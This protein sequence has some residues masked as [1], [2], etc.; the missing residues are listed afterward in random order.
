MV[1]SK[2]DESTLT[3]KEL[4]RRKDTLEAAKLR[5]E[6]WRQRQK[7]A[8]AQLRYKGQPTPYST[9]DPITL[10]DEEN[11]VAQEIINAALAQVARISCEDSLA[12]LIASQKEAIAQAQAKWVMPNWYGSTPVTLFTTPEY[13]RTRITDNDPMRPRIKFLI[14]HQLPAIQNL[15]ANQIT[16]LREYQD[17]VH[18]NT[19]NAVGV[20]QP[21]NRVLRG[22]SEPQYS[23]WQTKAAIQQ[24]NKMM[25]LLD[26]SFAQT[27]TPENII[28]Y[29]GI[30][31]PG[32]Y[33]R[34]GA[35]HAGN[36]AREF[37]SWRLG[38]IRSDA[39]YVH[40]T[41]SRRIASEIFT[42]GHDDGTTEPYV[43]EYRVPAGTNAIAMNAAN[44]NSK[45]ANT[46]ELLINRDTQFMVIAKYD[47]VKDGVTIHRGVVDVLPPASQAGRKKLP[48]FK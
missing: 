42:L 36:F 4:Q 9:V 19:Q 35:A 38:E 20:Y 5:A 33:P 2:I 12:A 39:A 14:D 43:I 23:Q 47:E 8:A 28:T 41:L 46:V 18:W 1:R 24:I 13:K 45:Y 21:V 16:A 26:S 3:P 32:V 15:S 10:S 11:A 30:R 31:G 25:R 37:A 6:R 7:D 17:G 29:R 27:V 34:K 44:P 40:T 22:Q 48:V